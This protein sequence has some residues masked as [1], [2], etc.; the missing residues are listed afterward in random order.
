MHFDRHIRFDLPPQGSVLARN[1]STRSCPPRTRA[2]S[3]REEDHENGMDGKSDQRNSA[4]KLNKKKTRRRHT[5]DPSKECFTLKFDLNVNIETEIIPAM[6]KKTLGEA[7]LPVFER[8]GIEFNQVEVFLDHSYTPL[9]LNFEAYR[10]GGHYLKVKA[11]PGSELKVEQALKEFKSL[12]LP[13]MRQSSASPAFICTPVPDRLE[14]PLQGRDS[15]DM[16]RSVTARASGLRSVT[17]RASGLRSVT[18]RASGLR[19]VTARAPGQRSVTARA[20]GLRS[21]TARASGLRSVT[22]RASGLRSV[23][24]RASGLRSVT[25]RAPGQRSVTARAPGQQLVIQE[26]SETE[27]S[28]SQRTVVS[29]GLSQRSVTARAPGQRSVTARAPGQTQSEPP[30]SGQSRPEPPASGQSRP[31][32]PASGQSRPE[33][34]AS[35]QSRP[36]PPACG[37]SRPEPPA[38]GQS[39]PEPPASGQSRPEPPAS[40]QSRPEPPAC[41][42]SRPEPPA[43]GQSRPEPPASGQSRPE[44]PASGQSRPEPPASGQS[45]PEPPASGQSRPE[46]PASGQTVELVLRGLVTALVQQCHAKSESLTARK[47]PTRLEENSLGPTSSHKTSAKAFPQA[48]SLSLFLCHSGVKHFQQLLA[49]SR[50]DMGPLFTADRVLKEFCHLDL[51]APMLGTSPDETR[52]LLLEGSLRMKEGKDSKVDVYC[53]LFTDIFLITKP[54]KKMEKTKVIRQP[55]LVDKIICREL[56]DPGSFLLIYLNEFRSLVAAYTFQTSVSGQCRVWIEAVFNAQNLLERLREQE[57]VQ[58]RCGLPNE[59]VESGNSATQSPSLLHKYT[60]T[61]ESQH[62][63]LDSLTGTVSMVIIDVNED[64]SSPDTPRAAPASHS[65]DTSLQSSAS[66]TTPIQELLDHGET[67]SGLLIPSAKGLVLES[68]GFRSASIDSAYGTLS[69][70]SVREFGERQRESADDPEE[71]THCQRSASPQIPVRS[72]LHESYVLK[73]KSEANLLQLISS[74]SESRELSQAT[75]NQSKSLNELWVPV[76]TAKGQLSELEK[77]A[78]S[79]PALST[80]HCPMTTKVRDAL[81]RAEALQLRASTHSGRRGR[82]VDTEGASRYSSNSDAE[83]SDGED[84]ECL[85]QCSCPVD[86]P[87]FDLGSKPCTLSLS[88]TEIE[89]IS[90]CVA[91]ELRAPHGQE[92][93]VRGQQGGSSTSERAKRTMSAPQPGQHRKLTLAQL[94]RIRTTLLLNSTLT[95]SEV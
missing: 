12:S 45:R 14:Q 70:S 84:L 8:K 77:G 54:V 30:A 64:L 65:D 46:P 39:R 9:P 29:H 60:D 75:L 79:R 15:A 38:S 95:A 40:G 81:R 51:T 49:T 3:D 48:A 18:A 62:S 25:A 26:G 61:L 10:F 41:G 69:P 72:L 50:R 78:L 28:L 74:S 94:Y 17:A 16:G 87:T 88:D 20:S 2:S 63:Q 32:P 36:E 85:K 1:V 57:S 80:P 82:D 34:P 68:D 37:Q 33:P 44:P 55:L 67:S 21:V 23:T 35:G 58:G 89:G 56:K 4:L 93:D 5:D 7:L 73:S 76:R 86:G 22:A 31:E 11:K 13:I 91:D 92:E 27:S 43:S 52:Q 66:A 71:S 53:F 59:D 42:Q 19:S 47:L 83:L 24:A 6:R 90:P